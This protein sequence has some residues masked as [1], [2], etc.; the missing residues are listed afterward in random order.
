VYIFVATGG[1]LDDY[2]VEDARRFVE[3]F[4]QSFES[5]HKDVLQAIKQT[6]DL[7]EETEATL[8]TAI[9]EFR[10]TFVPTEAGAGSDA[11]VGET[12]KPDDVK[13]DVGWDRMSS[14]DE[15]DDEGPGA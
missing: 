10:Q 3:E 11:A 14:A 15:P 4:G 12:T 8:R 13:P 2:P 7:S 6:G 1:F 9:E 5:R